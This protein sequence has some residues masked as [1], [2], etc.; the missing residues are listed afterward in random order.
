MRW[1]DGTT[2]PVLPVVVLSALLL[3]GA[4]VVAQQSS[5]TL[6]LTNVTVID[7][8]GS[9]PVS[10][11]T[12]LIADGR[13]V[14][15][16]ATSERPI[17]PGAEVLD[18]P[19][20][21]VIPGL[22]NNHVHYMRA[23]LGQAQGQERL[24]AEL[25]R[26]L[27]GGV[28]TVRDMAGDARR[29]RPLQQ[30]TRSGETIGPDVY[31][32]ALMAGPDFI[33][34]DQRV[35]VASAGVARGQAPWMQEVTDGTDLRRAVSRAVETGA[36]GLKLYAGVGVDVVRALTQEAHRRG[37]R[38]WAH[39]T[40]FPDR[41]I[42]V[43]T[44]GV[45]VVSHLCGLVWQDLDLDPSVN[46]PYTHTPP[47]DPRPS[48]DPSLV[49]ADSPEMTSLFREMTARGTML[50]ATLSL[51]ATARNSGEERG[52]AANLMTAIARSAVRAGVTITTGTD[53]FSPPDDPV[54]T[55]VREIEYLVAQNVLSPMEAL[56]A[57]T[58]NGAR[59]IGIED[60][61]GTIA[62]GKVANLVVLEADPSRDIQALRKVSLVIKRGARYERPHQEPVRP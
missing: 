59:A 48:F 3:V 4:P 30:A 20:R 54:P 8:T 49:Q 36:T 23:G 18:L 55:L 22:I 14:E 17:A 39:S 40:I 45:N 34:L 58:R 53:Y 27:Y 1:D 33:R 31:Y 37:L 6:A 2:I 41:P 50:D 56:V 19:G 32:A 42:A 51:S 52:C 35:S 9:A 28:T 13:I 57:A 10:G 15:V 21:V 47:D 16:V 26:Q 46:V 24:Q 43:V 61:V 25:R 11:R 5:A 12:I 7:G 38:V 60:S 29:L 44:A 62:A